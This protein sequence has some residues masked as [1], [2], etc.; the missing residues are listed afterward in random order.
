ME[1]YLRKKAEKSTGKNCTK[2]EKGKVDKF[3]KNID[4]H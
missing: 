3:Q 4:D 1:E 2:A